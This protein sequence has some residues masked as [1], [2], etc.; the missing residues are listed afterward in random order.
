MIKA[1]AQSIDLE[2]SLPFRRLHG[3]AVPTF[4]ITDPKTTSY[5]RFFDSSPFSSDSR[6]L[7]YVQIS[8]EAERF[9]SHSS[10][11]YPATVVVTDLI[12]GLTLKVATTRAWGRYEII[13]L[14]NLSI[15][16]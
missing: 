4:I 6:L 3:T 11:R 7:A 1:T 2:T 9:A 8:V 14:S 13:L 15:S 16:D 12:T 5:I 10:L